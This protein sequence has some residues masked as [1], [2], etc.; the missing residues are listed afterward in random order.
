MKEYLKSKKNFFIFALAL[1]LVST[2]IGV[3]FQPEFIKNYIGEMVKALLE[4]VKGKDFFQLFVFI[5]K[6]NLMISIFG[7]FLGIMLG[8]YPIFL[9]LINGYFIGFIISF[10]VGR[11]GLTAILSILPHGIFEIPAVII[12]L[13]LG[14]NLGF[15]LISNFA[16]LHKKSYWIFVL[17]IVPF[18]LFLALFIENLRVKK[19]KN[20]LIYELKN[21]GKVLVYVI[22][23]LLIVAGLIETILIFFK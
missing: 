10:A 6:N 16:S 3:F 9:L 17:A 7:M 15:K 13:G 5:F 23:P 19:L 2:V 20:L 1:F 12:S 4:Q 18:I 21:C 8:I 22:L 11:E 14:I